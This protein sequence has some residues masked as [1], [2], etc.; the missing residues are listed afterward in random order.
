MATAVLRPTDVA[1]QEA[2]VSSAAPSR[3]PVQHN[4]H[5]VL[6]YYNDPED[7]TPPAPFYVGHVSLGPLTASS[8]L[9]S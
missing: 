4:V 9:T 3:K 1:R 8:L 2:P 7:G 5:T 6:N